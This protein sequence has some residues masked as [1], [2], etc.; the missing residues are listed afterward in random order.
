[1]R[2]IVTSRP[3]GIGRGARARSSSRARPSSL[4]ATSVRPPSGADV[5]VGGPEEHELA[6]GQPRQDRRHRGQRVHPVAHRREV[7]DD[8]LHVGDGAGD[9]G[10]D[11]G[12]GGV[13]GAVDLDLGPRLEPA[14]DV[15]RVGSDVDEALSLVAHG[16][17]HRV[18]EQVDAEPAPLEHDP[19]RVDEERHVVGDDQ[20]DGVRRVPAVALA[21]GR[22][23]PR[24]ARAGLARAAQREVGDGD[25]VDVVELAVVDVVGRELGVVERQEPHEQ[26]VVGL[27]QRGDVAQPPERLGHG[28]AGDRPTGFAHGSRVVHRLPAFRPD[29]VVGVSTSPRRSVPGRREA[30]G[31]G[32]PP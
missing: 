28:V 23:D 24:H 13:V 4:P 11:G 10:L 9:L 17:Q 1:M 20:H 14:L 21:V 7:V 12:R 25:G 6:G 16:P 26:R 27:A 30:A 2:A 32:R 29:L 31:P 8:P 22:H 3:A 5:V 18:D 19:H 15:G